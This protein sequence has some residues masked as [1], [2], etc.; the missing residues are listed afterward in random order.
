MTA[1]V[2]EAPHPQHHPAMVAHLADR[3]GDVQLHIADT[4]TKFA[5]SM[6]FVYIHAVLFAVWCAT[7]LF[8]VDPFPF[9]FLT[10]SVSLEAIFLSTFVMIGQNR[11][12]DFAQRKADHDFHEQELELKVNTQLTRA[13]N[14]LVEEIH[15]QV[16]R[17]SRGPS[18][19]V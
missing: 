15:E 17:P 19:P 12:S 3:A 8:G 14:A 9:N 6:K 1:T 4:I 10:M 5:G 11:Q 7:G 13:I 2:T 18:S 16:C